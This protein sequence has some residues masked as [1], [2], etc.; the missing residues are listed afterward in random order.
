ME[1]ID[2]YN[3][4]KYRGLAEADVF[5]RVSHVDYVIDGINKD[6][7]IGYYELDVT[8]VPQV[9]VTTAKGIVD[10]VG[11]GTNP[12]LT[13]PPGF[14][15]AVTFSINNAALDLSVG[16][17]DNIYIQYSV[18]YRSAG[19]FDT[20]LPYMISTGVALDGVHFELWNASPSAAGAN[21]WQGD[22]YIY[23]ELRERE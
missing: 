5:A 4:R 7:E 17:R 18:Y 1:K 2:V 21:Q 12:T 14:T 9:N 13:P 20:A 10:I 11:M 6:G 3:Y 8:G 22:L 19:A 23:Y 16:N 15:G